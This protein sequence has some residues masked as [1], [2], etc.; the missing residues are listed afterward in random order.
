MLLTTLL[1]VS[2]GAKAT[3]IAVIGKIIVAIA[4]RACREQIM[5]K[6]N[7]INN[8][9]KELALNKDKSI[10][11][12]VLISKI[13]AM[14]WLIIANSQKNNAAFVAVPK[15]A[16]TLRNSIKDAIRYRIIEAKLKNRTMMSCSCMFS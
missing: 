2:I 12:A 10:P 11:R 5:N 4:A 3:Q 14:L 7:E 15:P 6:I 13:K 9:D 8:A 1:E 16:R